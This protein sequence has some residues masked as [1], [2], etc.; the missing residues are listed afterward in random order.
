MSI[1]AQIFNQMTAFTQKNFVSRVIT[2]IM[3]PELDNHSCCGMTF[4]H[5]CEKSS[6]QARS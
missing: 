2:I 4:L 1:Q 6:K 3:K 5:M